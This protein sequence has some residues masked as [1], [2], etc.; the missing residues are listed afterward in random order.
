MIPVIIKMHV[1]VVLWR[2]PKD[3]GYFTLNHHLF[4]TTVTISDST[5]I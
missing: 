5:F 4:L 3:I 2:K 1:Y